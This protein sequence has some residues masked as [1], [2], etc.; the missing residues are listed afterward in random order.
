MSESETIV[1][2]LSN[3]LFWDVDPS[4]LD[5]ERHERFLIVRVVERGSRQDVRQIRDFYGDHRM[6]EALVS[7]PSLEPR[8]IAFFANQF[9]LP[10]E[11]FRAY[12]RSNHWA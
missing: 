12:G 10:R 3:H 4:S 11:A 7:A 2:R 6:R 8:T 9:K 5:T 1:D